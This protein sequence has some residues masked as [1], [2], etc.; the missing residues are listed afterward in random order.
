M[1]MVLTLHIYIA[2]TLKDQI[3]PETVGGRDELEAGSHREAQ[4]TCRGFR[5]TGNPKHA[6]K[7]VIA[8]EDSADLNT[9]KDVEEIATDLFCEE[10]ETKLFA[11]SRRINAYWGEPSFFLLSQ[12]ISELGS[13]T[14][15]MVF[16]SI[17]SRSGI[18]S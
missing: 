3:V 8:E 5:L 11:D 13:K 2:R 16:L 4:R 18:A 9:E 12:F 14:H 17:L 1:L 15:W 6:R 7:V 10:T